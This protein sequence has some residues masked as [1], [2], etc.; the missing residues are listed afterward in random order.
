[1]A[2][3]LELLA[4]IHDL[5]LVPNVAPVQYAIRL[6]IPAGSKLLELPEVRA[7]AGLFDYTALCHP[8]RHP[9][10]CVDE[11]QQELLDLIATAMDQRAP[12]QDVFHKV[13]ERAA[14][15]TVDQMVRRLELDS[16]RPPD[17]VPYLTEPWYC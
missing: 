1:V 8:W 13:W 14:A 9:D 6:L 2:G 10:P 3:Y 4:T 5:G 15:R 16:G 12:R 11:L 17:Q 7:L